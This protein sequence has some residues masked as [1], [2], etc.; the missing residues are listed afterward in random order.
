ARLVISIG[1]LALAALAGGLAVE[2]VD[3][4]ASRE[5]PAAF[6]LVGGLILFAVGLG[7]L[8]W[9]MVARWN[10]AEPIDAPALRYRLY[11]ENS[12]E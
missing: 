11:W 3:G 5:R 10:A 7:A 12:E 2:V 8:A 4:S 9:R 6:A 1:A